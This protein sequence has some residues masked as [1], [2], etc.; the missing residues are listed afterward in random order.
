MCLLLV[1]VVVTYRRPNRLT[2]WAEIWHGSGD[3]PWDGCGWV[4]LTPP[5]VVGAAGETHKNGCEFICY[6]LV[7]KPLAK[8]APIWYQSK[9]DSEIAREW[10]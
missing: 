10:V 6:L 1:C 4:W 7:P 3:G 8:W 9:M 2:K 5:P